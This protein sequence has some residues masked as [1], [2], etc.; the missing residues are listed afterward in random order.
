M[1][2]IA[3]LNISGGKKC[4]ETVLDVSEGHNT[5]VFVNNNIYLYLLIGWNLMRG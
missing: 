3:G 2:W 1:S 5:F 4:C